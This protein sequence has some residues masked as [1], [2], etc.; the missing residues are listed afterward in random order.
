LNRLLA[1]RKELNLDKVAHFVYEA[2]GVNDPLLLSDEELANLYQVADAMF[3]PSRQEG[4]GIPILEA[5]LTR[6]PIFA[7]NLPPFHESAGVHAIFFAPDTPLNEV[8]TTITNSLQSDRAFQLRR[9]V[10]T[11]FTWRGV[12]ETRIL[13]LLTAVLPQSSG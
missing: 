6:L 7:T 4:F 9:R 3:F 13:P 5:G 1:I 12:V 10:L 2:K 11:H 8:A